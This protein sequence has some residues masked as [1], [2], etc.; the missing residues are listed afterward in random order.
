MTAGAAPSG[1]GGKNNFG[2]GIVF[3]AHGVE[4]TINALGRLQAAYSGLGEKTLKVGGA[5]G[6][7]EGASKASNE[8]AGDLSTQASALMQQGE[9]IKSWGDSIIG[10]L[11]GYVKKAAATGAEFDIIQ[12]QMTLAFRG[13]E[14]A[15][16]A[17]QAAMKVAESTNLLTTDVL[18]NV[19]SFKRQ[20]IDA[21]RSYTKELNGIPT[22][23]PALQL[24]SD[25]MMGSSQAAENISFNFQNA[26]KGSLRH[27]KEL[28]DG[29]EKAEEE[30][31]FKSAKTAQDRFDVVNQA[32][33]RLHGG[34]S[35]ASSESF[36]FISDNLEDVTQNIFGVLGTGLLN[37]FTPALSALFK[38]LSSLKENKP[39]MDTM[40][41]FM[42]DIGTLG[43]KAVTALVA[44]GKSI[45][46]LI[47]EHPKLMKVVISIVAGI[48]TILTV[49]GSMIIV[50]G[51][52]KMTYGVTFP[53]I[54]AGFKTIIRL[55]MTF[56]WYMLPLIALGY[57]FYKAWT[58]N[59]G[60]FKD[61][62]YVVID[63]IK[64]LWYLM[65]SWKDSTASMP[66]ELR[67]SLEKAGV[68]DWVVQIGG[69]LG[70]LKGIVLDLIDMFKQVASTLG[71]V[72]SP[73]FRAIIETLD[74][75]WNL[76]IDIVSAVFQ[77]DSSN[78]SGARASIEGISGAVQQAVQWLGALAERI[79]EG[80]VGVR[81]WLTKHRDAI[82]DTFVVI[83]HIIVRVL[84]I[85]INFGIQLHKAIAPAVRGLIGFLGYLLGL[86]VDIF[87]AV[88]K[89][90]SASLTGTLASVEGVG[91]ALKKVSDWIGELAKKVEYAFTKIRLWFEDHRETIIAVFSAIRDAIV[92]AIEI[93]INFG[94]QLYDTLAPVFWT[95]Y[96]TII[97]VASV[98]WDVIKALFG[99]NDTSTADIRIGVEWLRKGLDTVLWV[100]KKVAAGIQWVAKNVKD[101]FEEHKNTL[102][103]IANFIRGVVSFIIDIIVEL[104][105]QLW[106]VFKEDLYPSIEEVGKALYG[107]G[108]SLYNVYDT[109]ENSLKPILEPI[110]ELFSG[111]G[112]SLDWLSRDTEKIS[113]FSIII[114]TVLIPLQAMAALLYIIAKLIGVVLG[115]ITS[116]G[117]N[118][119]S[120]FLTA[121]TLLAALAEQMTATASLVAAL[122]NKDWKGASIAGARVDRANT[123]L[124]AATKDFGKSVGGLAASPLTGMMDPLKDLF[125]DEKLA[126]LLKNIVT[127]P[128]NT[129]TEEYGSPSLGK[130]IPGTGLYKKFASN[131]EDKPFAFPSGFSLP[132]PENE[133]FLE[134]MRQQKDQTTTQSKANDEMSGLRLEL[135]TL[136]STLLGTKS[137]NIVAGLAGEAL[138]GVDTDNFGQE[139]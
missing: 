41:G 39:F 75:L 138:K 107:V 25:L 96:D 43:A 31:A 81:A 90:D 85:I 126:G 4:E 63:A 50:A 55:A 134:L 82:I 61:G 130:D 33:L 86:F 22:E 93:I 56:S 8:L 83:R 32:I 36:K 45:T 24:M 101:F 26:M 18:R 29:Q 79:D 124:W 47:T 77:L 113:V 114:K 106:K 109:L 95:L 15:K 6:A 9:Q 54:A 62:V 49:L 133:K 3:E 87:K 11:Y 108:E 99:L 127:L 111:I 48:G 67:N 137:P 13:E 37:S 121:V 16:V 100:I 129:R 52:L 136:N 88:F 40:A 60:G 53:A 28:F 12:R 14:P 34:I 1:G 38:W 35:A 44:F 71:S 89:L 122:W 118:L 115:G 116:V 19:T 65:T 17:M 92:R 10:T 103:N 80:L 105:G 69:W 59:L 27:F 102:V 70:R 125:T 76:F 51:V 112:D 128:E 57:I 98:I 5:G 104:G 119:V 117:K 120:T 135:N 30:K 132:T 23:I 123:S 20:G 73:A 66:T 68:L 64:G 7:F 139:R 21:F 110:S 84:E 97:S 72:L 2:A 78:L 91:D 42:E 58:L 74:Y 94:T 46:D 131:F